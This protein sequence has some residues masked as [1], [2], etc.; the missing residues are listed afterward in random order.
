MPMLG[1]GRGRTRLAEMGGR[2]GDLSEMRSRLHDLRERVRTS[3]LPARALG[4]RPLAGL[5]GPPRR[6][7]GAGSLVLAGVGGALLGAAVM[8]LFD[9]EAGRRRR[10]F[11][12]ERL[13]RYVDRTTEA[14][15]VTS[16]D[17]VARTRGLVVELRDRVRGESRPDDGAE[18][19]RA[20]EAR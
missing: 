6:G 3:G 1:Y 4:T 14:V 15:D 2:L 5:I 17:V 9:P 7:A 12:R 18:E 11:L 20:P 19:V 16:R 8:Y 10:A 13:G